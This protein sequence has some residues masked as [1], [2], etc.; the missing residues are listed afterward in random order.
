MEDQLQADHVPDTETIGRLRGA[1]V[2]LETVRKSVD[3]A[4]ADRDEAMKTLLRPKR[5]S[6]TVPLPVR[7]LKKLEKKQPCPQRYL[8]RCTRSGCIFPNA[9]RRY[10][11]H[12][13][14]PF[15]I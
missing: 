2:N 1:I 13:I 4:R 6:M 10:R 5:R 3:K 12:R 8:Q 9:G 7:P 15:P 14:Y 11:S